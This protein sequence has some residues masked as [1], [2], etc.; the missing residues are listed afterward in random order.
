M[1]FGSLFD[2]FASIRFNNLIPMITSGLGN[3][4]LVKYL[5]GEVF[6]SSEKRI[7]ALREYYP[8]AQKKDWKLITAGQRVQVIKPVKGK[9]GVLQFGTEVI[10][11]PEN[12]IAGL[13]GASPG[14]STAA[15]IMIQVLERLFADR[16]TDWEP[17]LREIVP[18]YGKN[19]IDDHDLATRLLAE[20]AAT[21]KI[22]N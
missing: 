16:L 3:L 21:L 13:L 10:A 22:H 6:A 5:V 9:G 8:E 17:K 14:A 19:L 2:L 4:A 20:T 1:K 11:S 15:P 12:E 18:S 7:A